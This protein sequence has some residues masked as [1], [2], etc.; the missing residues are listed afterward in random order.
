MVVPLLHAHVWHDGVESE[1]LLDEN[2]VLLEFRVYRLP[3]HLRIRMVV[4][5]DGYIDGWDM[6][7][8]VYQDPRFGSDETERHWNLSLSIDGKHDLQRLEHVIVILMPHDR[9]AQGPF[10]FGLTE[11]LDVLDVRGVREDRKST[12]L[13]SSHSQIS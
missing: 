8:V 11:L 5:D 4:R 3:S 9:Y 6:P 7:S 13:N 10:F 12:R 1:A 2:D